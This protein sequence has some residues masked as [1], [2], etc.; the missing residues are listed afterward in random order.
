MPSKGIVYHQNL[1][2]MIQ[3][4]ID[5]Y[6]SASLLKE[7]LQNAD[8]AGAT[9]LIVT[10]D[11]QS[12]PELI[13]TPYEAAAGPALLMC[14]NTLFKEKDFLSIIEITGTG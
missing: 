2:H 12:Y 14:N 11:K 7:Y 9:E 1:I 10:Y 5:N 8:D 4:L 6:T 3:G 13:G